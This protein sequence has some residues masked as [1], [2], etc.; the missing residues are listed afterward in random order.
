MP[1]F[2]LLTEGGVP[3]SESA[4]LIFARSTKYGGLT[5][6]RRSRVAATA[7]AHPVT[8]S[9]EPEVGPDASVN[10]IAYSDVASVINS[11]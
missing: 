6:S 4:Q 8:D 10:I 11:R 7:Q 9:T 3:H 5:L 1:A 2:A